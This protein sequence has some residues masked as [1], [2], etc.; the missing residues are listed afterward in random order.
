MVYVISSYISR[1]YKYCK[2][3]QNYKKNSIFFKFLFTNQGALNFF[4]YAHELIPKNNYESL[5]DFYGSNEEI[6]FISCS[7]ILVGRTK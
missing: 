1:L 5:I 4:K 2:T 6:V 3:A 7:K